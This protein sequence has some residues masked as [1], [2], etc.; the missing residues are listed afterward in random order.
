MKALSGMADDRFP[1]CGEFAQSFVS[2]LDTDPAAALIEQ[3]VPVV[4]SAQL[5][6]AEDRPVVPPSM[7]VE[8]AEVTIITGE[9]PTETEATIATGEQKTDVVA[10]QPVLAADEQ[11]IITGDQ[12]AAEELI[13]AE[14]A[15]EELEVEEPEIEEPAAADQAVVMPDTSQFAPQPPSAARGQMIRSKLL[16]W[17]L[18]TVSLPRVDISE[19]RASLPANP[20]MQRR[21]LIDVGVSATLVVVILLVITLIAGRA[22]R[23]QQIAA[24]QETVQNAIDARDW[25]TADQE[26]AAL[27]KLAPSN[28]AATG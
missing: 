3:E 18:P 5:D 27:A 6:V 15:T 19:W 25:D 26:L 23:A 14:A 13:A 24:L 11:T 2:G 10:K 17:R 1:S 7:T 20:E 12:P 9:Q 4:E 21:L 28:A 16:R 22:G 8:E